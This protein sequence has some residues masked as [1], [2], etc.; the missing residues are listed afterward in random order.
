ME[1]KNMVRALSEDGGVVFCGVDSTALIQRMEQIHHTG[2]K[3]GVGPP[4]DGCQH[5]GHYA[6][7]S[8]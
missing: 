2:G 4:V 7:K 8:G 5:D 6:E 1:E 3:R